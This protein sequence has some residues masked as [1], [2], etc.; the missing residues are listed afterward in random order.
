MKKIAVVED[1]VFLRDE[2]KDI[3]EKQG[4]L[5]QIIDPANQPVEEIESFEPSLVVLDLNLPGPSGFD[6]CRSLKSR[7]ISP[8]LVL[9]C[10]DKLQDELHAL[11]LGADDYLTKPCNPKRLT[12]RIRRLLDIYEG[13]HTVIECSGIRYDE[14][15]NVILADEKT[16]HLSENERKL[17]RLLAGAYPDVVRKEDLIGSLWGSAEF[18]D[19]NIL[20]V[21]ITRLRR[22]IVEGGLG[23]RILNVRGSGYRLAVGGN[24]A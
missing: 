9:T 5:V 16:V 20:Q 13:R 4:F 2:L 15:A 11:D 23:C 1:D 8:V 17:F 22:T 19:E 10:R 18:V 14:A 12:A 3:L 24:E 6:I 7:G 21:N